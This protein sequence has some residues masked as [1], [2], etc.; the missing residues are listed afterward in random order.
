MA[1]DKVIDS[2]KLDAA[3]TATADAIRAKTG[4]TANLA[5]NESTGFKNAVEAIENKS[6][7]NLIGL[8]VVP[9]KADQRFDPP[10]N[11][12]GFGRVTVTAMPT[13]TQVTPTISINSSGLITASATQT[14]GYVDEGTKSAT[15]QLTTQA[16]KTVTPSTSSQT[17]VASG[18]YT[19]GAVTVA[20]IPSTY[21][22]PTATKTATTYTPT[23]SNQTID[24]G[25]Y[26]S[27][28]QTIKGDSNLVSSN[29]KSGVS[30]FGVTGNFAG[31]TMQ[32]ATG[33][34]TPDTTTSSTVGTELFSLSG[35][36]FKPK[37]VVIRM[38]GKLDSTNFGSYY[39]VGAVFGSSIS[40][41]WNGRMISYT[42]GPYNRLDDQFDV[43]FAF[44]SSGFI[45]R[46][47]ESGE[48]KMHS[49]YQYLAIG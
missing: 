39:N 46:Q 18:V 38:S 37:F 42:K 31:E 30:I 40:E 2:A 23:T 48:H 29:I 22:K 35:L 47:K 43:E 34:I 16:A 1:Y 6:E 33:T 5:W 19:T 12:D 25:T 3:M 49:S 27:G 26:C 13:A 20:A 14:A 24:S 21:V 11:Y 32:Y 7:P 41:A 28:T 4:G 36:S 10:E 44:T 8:E 15:K 17:A 45:V 9:T